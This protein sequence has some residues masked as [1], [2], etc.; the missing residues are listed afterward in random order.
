[1][2]ASLAV[3][4][5]SL[6]PETVRHYVV[7][8]GRS[9]RWIAR[10][11]GCAPAAVSRMITRTGLDRDRQRAADARAPARMARAAEIVACRR[12]GVELEEVARRFGVAAS[13]VADLVAIA[14]AAEERAARA[15]RLADLSARLATLPARRSVVVPTRVIGPGYGG[16][17]DVEH[18]DAALAAADA[19][20]WR[21][22][23][24]PKSPRPPA[25]TMTGSPAQMCAEAGT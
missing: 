3:T 15:A 9:P 8:E 25:R 4:T 23:R 11:L 2:D 24:Y 1:M 12:S 21:G 20:P 10:K 22:G 18:A 14:V 5:P 13:W 7:D 16:S 19:A 17:P 6:D